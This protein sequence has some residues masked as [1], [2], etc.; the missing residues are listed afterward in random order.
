MQSKSSQSSEKQTHKVDTS[1]SRCFVYL[2]SVLVGHHV[3][4][5]DNE[6]V[7]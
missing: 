6:S 1:F 5:G 4:V 3:G 7:L 2:Y